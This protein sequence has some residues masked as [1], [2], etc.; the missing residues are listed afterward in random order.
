M[1]T[2]NGESILIPQ[3]EEG[4][5]EAKWVSFNESESLASCSYPNI[6]EVA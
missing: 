1:M 6:Q 2:Y 5:L 3:K 4:I